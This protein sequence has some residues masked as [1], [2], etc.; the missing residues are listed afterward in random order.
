MKKSVVVVVALVLV[1]I[2]GF[3]S[4]RHVR[5]DDSP[6]KMTELEAARLTNAWLQAQI[7]SRECNER[8]QKPFSLLKETGAKYR[9]DP[10]Q[11]NQ[12]VFVDEQGVITRKTPTK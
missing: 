10:V 8:L 7:L 3:F 9:F 6:S 5:A 11:L 2:I 4:A 12:T 1:L